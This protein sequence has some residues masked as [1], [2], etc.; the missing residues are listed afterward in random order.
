MSAFRAKPNLEYETAIHGKTLVAMFC[1]LVRLQPPAARSETSSNSLYMVPRSL[2]IPQ[3]SAIT[4]RGARYS[5]IHPPLSQQEKK[6]PEKTHRTHQN[7]KER[8]HKRE[9]ER[10]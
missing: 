10:K 3:N 7:L 4:L 6:T 1:T 9:G 5:T 8:K 2:L